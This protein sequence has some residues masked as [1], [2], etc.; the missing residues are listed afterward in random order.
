MFAEGELGFDYFKTDRQV[1]LV[2]FLA[3]DVR[4]KP[5]LLNSRLPRPILGALHECLPDPLV[6]VGFIHNQ[7]ADL[8]IKVRLDRSA[9]INV[10]PTDREAV[11]ISQKDSMIRAGKNASQAGS[12]LLRCGWVAELAAEVSQGRNIVR[13][14]GA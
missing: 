6:A 7:A 8:G 1:E 4:A 11:H 9:G 14:G 13:E 12:Y 5:E 10:H 2:G 3:N